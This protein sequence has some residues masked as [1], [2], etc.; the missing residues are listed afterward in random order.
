M[1]KYPVSQPKHILW[2]LNILSTKIYVKTF[3]ILRSKVFI[4]LELW[5]YMHYVYPDIYKCW[6]LISTMDLDNILRKTIEGYLDSVPSLT[7]NTI[8]TKLIMHAFHSSRYL[9]SKWMFV[10]SHASMI[11]VQYM[12]KWCN[13]LYCKVTSIQKWLKPIFIVC[14]P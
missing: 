9:Q 7:F 4:Y 10:L 5:E 3:P 6:V 11:N 2:V 14:I 12:S 13:P 1:N 8:K